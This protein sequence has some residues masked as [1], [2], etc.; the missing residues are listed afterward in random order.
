MRLGKCLWLGP[1][2]ALIL[3]TAAAADE[4]AIIKLH[5]PI[6]SKGKTVLEALRD[7][8]S[9]RVY[10]AGELSRQELSEIL[11]AAGGINRLE[12]EEGG[13]GRTAPSSFNLQ[14]IDIYAFTQAAV[15][16]YDPKGHR[17]VP[18][19]SGDH[20]AAAGIQQYVATAP[21]NLVYVVD[22]AKLHGETGEEKKIAA[23]MDVGHN[24]ENVYLYSASAG[25]NVIARSSVDPEV[26]RRLLK[27]GD[28]FL[29]LL[30]QTVGPAVGRK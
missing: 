13:V 10:G 7:R 6:F 15:Y 9:E 21:L 27:L 24:S 19:L 20:R 3:A 25:L 30:G 17:L 22:L 23:G 4:P 2:L 28:S 18:V 26:L 29:P 11:W 16:K 8:H 1:V 5:Q 14:P 12:M